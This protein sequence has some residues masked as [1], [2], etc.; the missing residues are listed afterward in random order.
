MDKFIAFSGPSSTTHDSE[1]YR[2]YTPED[3]VPIFK[4]HGGIKIYIF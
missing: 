4:Q 2:T 3:Y 1:G